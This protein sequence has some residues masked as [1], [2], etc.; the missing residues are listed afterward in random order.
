MIGVPLA[1][2][3]LTNSQS[4]HIT[5]SKTYATPTPTP[6]VPPNQNVVSFTVSYPNGTAVPATLDQSAL[7]A[8]WLT[9]PSNAPPADPNYFVIKNTGTVPI[10]V[11]VNEQNVKAS[12]TSPN[13]LDFTV[14]VQGTGAT[15]NPGESKQIS[16]YIWIY[17]L[18]GEPNGPRFGGSGTLT[19]SYDVVIQATQA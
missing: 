16:F 5:G 18:Y 8:R 19:Y 10:T 2:A 4:I 1:V 6:S 14:D 15:L 13:T 3:A 12:S 7:S 17:E 11:G 9:T